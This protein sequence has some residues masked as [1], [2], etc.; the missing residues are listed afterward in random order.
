MRERPNLL[1]PAVMTLV[2]GALVVGLAARATGRAFDGFDL[3][4][5]ALL[6]GWLAL[7]ATGLIASGRITGGQALRH[8]LAWAA[9]CV[10]LVVAFWA[11]RPF[12]PPD[13]P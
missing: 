11:L 1:W 12:L 7:L 6:L 4:R 2:I 13:W 10:T 5:I 9:I 8:G 3:A